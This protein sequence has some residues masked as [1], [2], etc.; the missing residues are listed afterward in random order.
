MT[1]QPSTT[2][3]MCNRHT[4]PPVHAEVALAAGGDSMFNLSHNV[5]NEQKLYE[6]HSRILN[7]Q[8]L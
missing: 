8:K 2:A 6:V 4:S 3:K 1:R 5:T 7:R